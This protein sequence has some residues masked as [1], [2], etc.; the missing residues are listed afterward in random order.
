MALRS[1]QGIVLRGYPFGE[2]HRVVV[3]LSPNHGKVR[4]VAKGVRKTRSRFGGRLEPFT[5]VDVV[6]YEGTNLDTITQ[7]SIINAFAHLR[8]DLDRVLAA[9]TMIEVVDAVA[10]EDEPSQRLFLL[11]HRGL[12]VLDAA[13]P[14][15]DLVTSFL[16]KA[17]DIIG[18]APALS[19]CAGCGRPDALTRFSF[20]AGGS[21]CDDCRTPG[22]YALREGLVPYLA[23]VATSD[24]SNLPDADRSFSRE[25]LGVTKRFVEYHLE[26]EL[27][28]MAMLD[29]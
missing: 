13:P 8:N 7:V 10:Q 4:T 5:H 16:L 9:G 19:S 29:G 23:T 24:L 20:A 3:L 21:L 25:A 18:V 1:D 12:S 6:L 17:A 15:P 27:G 22:A 14:H 26:R 28:S 2:S 11:L